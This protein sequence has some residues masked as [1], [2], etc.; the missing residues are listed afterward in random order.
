MSLIVVKKISPADTLFIRQKVL[1]SKLAVNECVFPGDNLPTTHHFGAFEQNQIIGIVSLF[2]QLPNDSSP[3]GGMQIR[4]MATL[5][6]YRGK[7]IGRQ[8]LENAELFAF[9]HGVKYLWANAR[10]SAKEFYRKA[11]YSINE[12]VFNIEGVG[13]HVLIHKNNPITCFEGE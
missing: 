6:E 12:N 13:M 9:E 10:V 1:R 4:A 11:G 2:Q 7:G 8:L 5:K 3:I